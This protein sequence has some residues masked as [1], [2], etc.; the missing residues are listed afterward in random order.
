MHNLGWSLYK[1][2]NNPLKSNSAEQCYHPINASISADKNAEQPT[3]Q[4]SCETTYTVC[5]DES[6]R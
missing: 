2:A 5:L 3:Q 6:H 4:N 1:T